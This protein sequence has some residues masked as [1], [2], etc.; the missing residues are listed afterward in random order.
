VGAWVGAACG[1]DPAANQTASA[2]SEGDD[3]GD[4]DDDD[5]GPVVDDG[6][7]TDVDSSGTSVSASTGSSDGDGSTSSADSSSDDSANTDSSS[8]DSASTGT[9]SDSSSGESSDSTTAGE[10]EG[11]LDCDPFAQDC[12]P[13]EKCSAW[14]DDGGDSWNATHCVP[15][16]PAPAQPGEPCTV[17]GSPVSGVDNC[18]IG[19][20]CWDVDFD[21][22]M[23]TCIALCTGSIDDPDCA[24][25]S[26]SC[27]ISND[28]SLNLCL[29]TCNP[30]L[31]DCPAG[32]GC[33]PG[34]EA[35]H[36]SPDASGAAGAQGDEC[37]FVNV[38][39]PGLACVFGD[40]AGCADDTCCSQYCD[41]TDLTACTDMG[42]FCY[43]W[44]GM[45]EAPPG[46]DFVGVCGV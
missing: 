37:L 18:D 28:D 34:D 12:G 25:A 23:G 44:Y 17:L 21:T 26:T 42:M 46:L 8:T 40:F 7:D 24:D 31:G 3:D 19:A 22:G 6:S 32:Q 39:D 14:A 20:M 35:F 2:S 38:C 13:G 27:Q 29:P 10:T 30:L 15:I 4:D 43:A 1:D 5:D 41:I 16:D 11:T 36:C 9:S 33:Y 45:G